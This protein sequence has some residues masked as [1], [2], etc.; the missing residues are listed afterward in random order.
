MPSE[1]FSNLTKENILRMFNEVSRKPE[2][3]IGKMMTIKYFGL[4]DAGIPRF[5]IA[6]ALRNYE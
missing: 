3:Y 6:I 4:T 2:T 5:P 1:T